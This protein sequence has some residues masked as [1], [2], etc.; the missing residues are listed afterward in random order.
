MMQFAG[1]ECIV[2]MERYRDGSPCIRLISAIGEPL[3]TATVCVAGRKAP[4]GY[5]FIKD[6]GEN[7][8][9]LDALIAAHLV[10]DTGYRVPVGHAEACIVKLL[11]ENIP[12]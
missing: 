4:D 12:K 11:V 10:A 5:G 8:G 3:G 2:R 9:M 6:Y 7:A 1:Y